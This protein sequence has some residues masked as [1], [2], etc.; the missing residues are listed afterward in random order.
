MSNTSIEILSQRGMRA[1]PSVLAAL[2]NLLP[3]PRESP[4]AS[5]LGRKAKWLKGKRGVAVNRLLHVSRCRLA[6]P[7]ARDL[8]TG[9]PGC[10]GAKR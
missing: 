6:A 5:L 4:V 10:R 8:D 9:L 7:I 3:G 2:V 1:A